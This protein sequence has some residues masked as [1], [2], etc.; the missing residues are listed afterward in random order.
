M[1]SQLPP[2]LFIP[3]LLLAATALAVPAA[4]P[5]ALP[6]IFA[7]RQGSCPTTSLWANYYYTTLVLS[8]TTITNGYSTLGFV[9]STSTESETRTINTIST[10]LSPSVVTLESKSASPPTNSHV[11]AS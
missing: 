7:P 2:L 6:A 3:A 8:T 4:Y 1:L 11:S 10:A 9:T 5:V